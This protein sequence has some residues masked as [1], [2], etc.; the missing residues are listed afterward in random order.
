MT[1][2]CASAW[3]KKVP[4]RSEK[5]STFEALA[6]N[7]AVATAMR[8]INPDVIAAYPIT[9][10]TST[11]QKFADF[12]AD[13]LVDTEFVTVE[14]EHSAMSACVGA[15]AAGARVMTATSANGLALMWEIVYIAS[16]NRCPI[17]MSLVNR[18]LSGPINIHT[19]HSDA[20]G[21][22][23]A[24]WIMMFSENGQ[25]A[26]DNIIQGM[27]IAEHKDILLPVAVCQ[28]GFITSHGLERV[29]IYD[30]KDVKSFVGEYSP[31]WPLLDLEHP[32]TYGPLDFYDYYFEHKRQ[33]VDAMEKAQ[34]VILEVAAEF[35]K[36]FKRD[37]GL[38]EG[39]RIDDADTAI[40]AANSTAGTA[41]VVVD[42][43]R[44]EG[45]KVGLIKPRLFRPF[46]AK[47]LAEAMS[48]LKSVAVLDRSA[49]FGAMDNAGP[50]FL[51]I[52][53]GLAVNGVQV[54][55]VDYVYGLGGRD[56]L[57]SQIEGV[58]QEALEI[59][60]AGGAEQAVTYL[61]VRE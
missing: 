40:V 12:V 59:G 51:E 16:S 47:E 42:R 3:S 35:N 41:K 33:Q 29:E 34:A 31:Q 18:A 20:M 55:V 15:S 8:Q 61:G 5:M 26:Y 38:F 30:D 19:D 39:Y 25:E 1:S 14:S 9:P 11:V 37:Y 58:F 52:V 45:R 46:P 50:L 57:P 53:A 10:Q 21:M 4:S 44:E 48:H 56:I 17:V 28:D 13:G 36:K 23:D 60:E 2:G 24:S 7:E 49:S 54:P 22:R 43:M 6:G 32:K 27:R